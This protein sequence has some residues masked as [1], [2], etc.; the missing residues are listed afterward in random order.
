MTESEFGR[1]HGE[2]GGAHFSWRRRSQLPSCAG[3]EQAKK[4]ETELLASLETLAARKAA[5]PVAEEPGDPADNLPYGWEQACRQSLTSFSRADIYDTCDSL[6]LS[7]RA[8]AG[9][10]PA[11]GATGSPACGQ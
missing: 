1:A 8:I 7:Q 6:S 9:G 11:G 10:A 5:G 4:R 3:C 2:E